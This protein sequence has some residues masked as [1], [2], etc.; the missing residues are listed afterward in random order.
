MSNLGKIVVCPYYINEKDTTITCEDTMRV[1]S[2]KAVKESHS[3]QYCCESW[4]ECPYTVDLEELYERIEEMSESQKQVE[5]LKHYNHKQKYEIRRLRKELEESSRNEKSA[6]HLA[7][8]LETRVKS[9]DQRLF[10]MDQKVKSLEMFAG[11][12]CS[13]NNQQEYNLDDVREFA[14]RHESRC[15]IDEDKPGVFVVE[16][17]EKTGD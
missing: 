17:K 15:K 9:R 12:L 8:S 2:S 6:I 16:T 3:R 7:K 4:R 5:K 11:Y 14:L 13:L 10:V 1:Y